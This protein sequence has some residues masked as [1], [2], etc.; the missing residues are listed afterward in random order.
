VRSRKYRPVHN[1]GHLRY[2]ECGKIDSQGKKFRPNSKSLPR[3]Q[4]KIMLIKYFSKTTLDI[5]A[6]IFTTPKMRGEFHV[7]SPIGKNR[8]PSFHPWL[9][10][11]APAD[12]K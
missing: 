2:I 3:S 5:I 9:W 7:V 6:T 11:Y 12:E 4:Q 8:L 10:V 1:I